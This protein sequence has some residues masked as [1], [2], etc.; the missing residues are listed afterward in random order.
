MIMEQL[1]AALKAAAEPTRLR[2]LA[3]LARG[4]L[5]VTEIT[6]VLHQSQPRVS[7]HL[8]LLCDAG[9][10]ERLPEGAWVF[11]RLAERG[12]G[13]RCARTLL[14][15]LPADDHEP[16]R[17][18]ERLDRVRR[19]RAERAAAYFRD[20]AA[21][22]DRIRKLYVGETAVE[23]AMLEAAGDA[24]VGDLVDLGTGTGR[25]LEVFAPRVRRGIGIDDSHEM[26]NVAR[27]KLDARGITNCQVRRGNLYN[28]PLPSA[29]A[30]LVTVHQVLHFLDD[31]AVALKEAA[32]LL[33]ADGR[34]LLVDFA[35]HGLEF[36]RADYAHRRLGFADEEVTR[37]CKAAG[38]SAVKVRHLNAAG[39]AGHDALTVSL[40][41]ATQP[42]SA[43][44]AVA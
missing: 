10:L 19:E 7:R 18:L 15:L 9:L 5:T 31:P 23:H 32:R 27:A 33:R 6:R 28:V 21:S 44:R 11:Y 30:D 39:K 37:W 1:L 17:D 12:E 3:L 14:G 29:C 34:L 26:L 43:R 42:A 41:T 25:V 16:A 8:K 35:P 24:E 2:L 13:A 4:E 40:W 38:L 20:N 36:L 22:W